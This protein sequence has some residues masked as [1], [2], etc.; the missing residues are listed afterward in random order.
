MPNLIFTGRFQPL[1]N[2][3]IMMLRAIKK[4]YPDDLLIICIVRKTHKKLEPET[5]TTFYKK[6]EIKQSEVNNP[7]P[8]WERFML[9]KTA[10]ENDD[11][12]KKNTV[13]LFRERPDIN[14]EKS[15]IDLP[16]DRIFILPSIQ[17]DEFDAEKLSFY[18]NL[19]EHIE[20]ITAERTTYSATDI[21]TALKSGDCDLSFMPKSCRDYFLSH[22]LK[23][24]KTN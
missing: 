12:L 14:W 16:N 13:I 11:L 6:S 3:H 23:Y 17:K 8:N 15:I 10:I 2:G 19:S 21:R 9:M 20:M 4:A 1:H 22:C 7:L 24:F 18:K 5:K